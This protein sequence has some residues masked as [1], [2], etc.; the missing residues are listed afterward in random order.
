MGR[1]IAEEPDKVIFESQALGRIE[2]PRGRIERIERD[3]AP[4]SQPFTPPVSRLA[5]QAS[6]GPF[7]RTEW[8][9]EP[10]LEVR[11]HQR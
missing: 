11:F 3:A 9:D 10:K 2:V 8:R 7:R 6:R 1:V 5:I 4:P